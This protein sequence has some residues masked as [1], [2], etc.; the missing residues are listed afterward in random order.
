M[1]KEDTSAPR[2]RGDNPDY[3][4]DAMRYAVCSSYIRS[5][6]VGGYAGKLMDVALH[7]GT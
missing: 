3:R 6:S 2:T 7:I 5:Q 4:I 1:S